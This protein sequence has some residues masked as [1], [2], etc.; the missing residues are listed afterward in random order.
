MILFLFYFT[1]FFTAYLVLLVLAG[2]RRPPLAPYP[3]TPLVSI[4]VAVRNEAEP[5]IRCLEAIA[6]LNYPPERIEVLLGDDA[7]TDNTAALIQ[8]FIRD[9]PRF[10]YLFI[11]NQLGQ[12]RG[13]ANVLAHLSRAASSNFFLI[14][15]ADT[16]VPPD[17]I[18]RML[19]GLKKDTGI[20]TGIT[21]IAG[22]NLFARMQDLDWINALG[23]MQ[24]VSDLGVPVSTMGNNV[25]ITRQA[26]EATG[27]YENLPFSVTE[28]VQLFQAVIRQGLGTKNIFDAGVLA[29]ST[30]VPTVGALWQQRKRWMQGVKFLPWYMMLFVGVF[31]SYYSFMLALG[32]YVSWPAMMGVFFGKV[33]LQTA[34]IHSCLRRLGL[35]KPV[36]VLLL[37]EFYLIF[38]SLISLSFFLFPGKITWKGRKY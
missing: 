22:R 23:L 36:W 29:F 14:T 13:K 6:R 12:A 2:H 32:L 4:L 10:R 21:S 30:P 17:W 1:L 8:R 35:R 18:R 3:A 33:I 38:V 34:F 28:D 37:F 11:Q 20:V 26:Y 25:L 9:K 27:G 7:S 16:A 15:D 31:G 24:V 19:A 5:I